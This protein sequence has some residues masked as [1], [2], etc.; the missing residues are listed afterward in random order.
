M[1]IA[2]M[3][4]GAL[5][6]YLVALFILMIGLGLFPYFLDHPG[7]VVCNSV[8]ALVAY[9]VV[10]VG[11]GI[12]L[13][14]VVERKVIIGGIITINAVAF[15]LIG[16]FSIFLGLDVFIRSGFI[17][18]Y[19]SSLTIQVVVSNMLGFTRVD[20]L[21]SLWSDSAPYAI[22]EGCVPLSS[23]P[24]F[25]WLIL[26]SILVITAFGIVIQTLPDRK[27][28]PTTLPVAA[29]KPPSS[30]KPPP[31]ATWWPWSSPPPA[32]PKPKPAPPPAPSPPEGPKTWWNGHVGSGWSPK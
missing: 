19:S 11:V 17:E 22:A 32:A 13:V 18:V 27:K 1:R 29:P 16:S 12:V 23:V 21:P 30:P 4:T 2:L 28:K 7:T 24:K 10:F 25:V 31:P 15:G 14:I 6:T 9:N 8:E 5:F 20:I 26:P 3:I